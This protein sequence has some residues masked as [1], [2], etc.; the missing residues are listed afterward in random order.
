MAF[1]NPNCS[2]TKTNIIKK[3]NKENNTVLN[4]KDKIDILKRWAYDERELEVAEEENMSKASDDY[5]A[6]I[7]DEILLC[8]LELGVEGDQPE[9]PPTKHG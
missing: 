4:K 9:H 1:S 6:N 3:G 8:L 7:L 5:H 2:E